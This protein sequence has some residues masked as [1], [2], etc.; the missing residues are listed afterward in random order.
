[1]EYFAFSILVMASLA[2][3]IARCQNQESYTETI[4][5]PYDLDNSDT[6]ASIPITTT[7]EPLESVTLCLSFRVDALKDKILDEIGIFELVADQT[8][9]S[10]V[11]L[12]VSSIGFYSAAYHDQYGLIMDE[13]KFDLSTWIR[14]CYAIDH[15][16]STIVVNGA[17]CHTGRG[18][19]MWKTWGFAQLGGLQLGK[20]KWFVVI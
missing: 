10:R 8:D 15:S 7:E 18:R 1:M 3:R 17:R 12:Q 19:E 9:V 11:V 20:A 5:F 2:W 14:I 16:S 4:Q 6:F 13:T